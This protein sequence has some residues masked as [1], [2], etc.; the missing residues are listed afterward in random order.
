MSSMLGGNEDLVVLAG[1]V[2]GWGSSWFPR[3]CNVLLLKGLGDL[4]LTGRA[5]AVRENPTWRRLE[6]MVCRRAERSG[7]H[8][9][10]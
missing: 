6:G 7:S 10:G 3:P 1:G 9:P 4:V 5:P 8:V 2:Q